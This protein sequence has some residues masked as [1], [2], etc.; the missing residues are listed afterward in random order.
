M[1]AK[2]AYFLFFAILALMPGASLAVDTYPIAI[3]IWEPPFNT[4]RERISGEYKP[5]PAATKEWKICVSIPHLKDA[6]WLA[7][8]YAV[9]DEAARLGVAVNLFEAGGYDHLDRQL[10][11]VRECM[12]SGGDGL[13]LSAVQFDGFDDLIQSYTNQGRPVVDLI[14]G[15]NPKYITARTAATFWDN[16]YLAGR[17]IVDQQKKRTEPLRV[18]W[19]PGPKGAGWVSAADKGFNEAIAGSTVQLVATKY[20]DTGREVQARLVQEV[21]KATPDVD[22]IAGTAVTAEAAIKVLRQK[23]LTDKITVLP[24]YYGPGVHKGIARGLFP[25]APSDMQGFQARLAMDTIV[26]VLEGA[27]YRKHIGARVQLIDRLGL[28][29]F[30]ESSSLPPSGFRPIFS[31]G[32]WWNR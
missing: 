8:N 9:V 11:Q 5:F 13:I 1:P 4:Q 21:L 16:G 15:V 23:G 29:G 6:Y 26:R 2:L 30:D 17:Y 31:Y 14:N 10:A 27:P 32:K 22:Y 18:V 12:G 25:A 3:D 19:F 24:Y 7:V 28:R 20:G